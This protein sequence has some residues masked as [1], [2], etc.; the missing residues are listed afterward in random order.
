[1]IPSNRRP[2]HVYSIGQN[3]SFRGLQSTIV[4]IVL[5]FSCPKRKS[6]L[7]VLLEG[8]WLDR[9]SIVKVD[10]WTLR[11]CRWCGRSSTSFLYIYIYITP[12]QST[13]T[14]L[15]LKKAHFKG[16]FFSTELR[17]DIFRIQ[18]T[19][20]QI[21]GSRLLLGGRN[22]KISVTR[23]PVYSVSTL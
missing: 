9:N 10:F 6:S 4:S 15:F 2:W 14:F 12:N 8:H 22:R 20:W 18:L 3:L 23:E 11:A 17:V 1:M 16:H 7:L 21:A 5:I 13:Y 19:L